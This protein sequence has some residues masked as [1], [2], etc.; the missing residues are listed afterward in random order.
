MFEGITIS[1][2]NAMKFQAKILVDCIVVDGQL[3]GSVPGAMVGPL[4]NS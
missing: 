3:V 2:Q 1:K 4:I